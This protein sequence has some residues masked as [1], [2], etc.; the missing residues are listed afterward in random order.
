MNNAETV[1]ILIPSLLSF[2]I[3][4]IQIQKFFLFEIFMTSLMREKLYNE[5]FKNFVQKNK[6]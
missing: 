4:N 6:V 5:P 3:Y 1:K 2:Y